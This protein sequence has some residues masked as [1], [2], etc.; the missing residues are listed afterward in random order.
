MV[1]TAYFVR[2]S[3]LHLQKMFAKHFYQY[4]KHLKAIDLLDNILNYPKKALGLQRFEHSFYLH[5]LYN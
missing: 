3:L 2:A 5:D 4:Q 1:W